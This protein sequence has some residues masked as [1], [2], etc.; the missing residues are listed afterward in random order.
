MVPDETSM[1]DKYLEAL[2]GRDKNWETAES[3]MSR[4]DTSNVVPVETRVPWVKQ[5]HAAGSQA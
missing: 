1:V 2:T 5:E 4:A 3:G